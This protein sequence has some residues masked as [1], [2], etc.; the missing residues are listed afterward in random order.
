MSRL[1]RL[2]NNTNVQKAQG[3]KV[4]NTYLSTTKVECSAEELTKIAD[5]CCKQKLFE[6]F[7]EYLFVYRKSDD[8]Y[9]TSLMLRL[10][11]G[12]LDALLVAARI[13]S[14]DMTANK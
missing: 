7:A 9:L 8:E 2:S 4:F 10:F 13:S 6:D 3:G 5:F 14:L 1:R 11:K 12:L